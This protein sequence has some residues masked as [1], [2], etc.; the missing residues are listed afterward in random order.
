M[1]AVVIDQ[2]LKKEEGLWECYSSLQS[3]RMA[4]TNIAILYALMRT[5][6]RN[7]RSIFSISLKDLRLRVRMDYRQRPYYSIYVGM[8]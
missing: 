6:T 8:C 4:M 2:K 3:C 1:L 7:L 5:W